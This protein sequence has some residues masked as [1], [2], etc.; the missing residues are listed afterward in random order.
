[1]LEREVVTEEQR[2]NCPDYLTVAHV[3]SRYCCEIFSAKNLCHNFGP[4]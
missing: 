3:C 2:Y 4:P 1:M